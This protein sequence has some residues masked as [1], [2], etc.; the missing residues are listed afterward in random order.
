MGCKIIVGRNDSGQGTE[1]ACFYDSVTDTVFGVMLEDLEEAESF[2]TWNL[3]EWDSE[4]LRTLSH[5]EFIERLDK[6]REERRESLK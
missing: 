3:Q 5:E 2:Q 6:F 4:D 1:C